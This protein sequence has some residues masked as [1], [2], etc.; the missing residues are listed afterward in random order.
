MPVRLL[1]LPHHQDAFAIRSTKGRARSNRRKQQAE[2]QE[3]EEPVEMKEEE[4]DF[5]GA[6]S[7]P[8]QH[9]R[10]H[11][12]ASF[13]EFNQ[14]SEDEPDK[15]V[16]EGG[17]FWDEKEDDFWG[18]SSAAST[19]KKVDS[20]VDK[21]LDDFGSMFQIKV[22]DNVHENVKSGGGVGT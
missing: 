15:K 13:S 17:S 5:F 21:I 1:F 18:S 4:D 14:V 3:D 6:S 20:R 2:V 8:K 19:K 22:S 9:E 10:R 16:E 11:V 12:D 7:A